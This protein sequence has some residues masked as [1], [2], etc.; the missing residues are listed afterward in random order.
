MKTYKGEE[1][2]V[3]GLPLFRDCFPPKCPTM[4]LAHC[5]KL[6]MRSD[7]EKRG[8][9]VTING[10]SRG[11][12]TQDIESMRKEETELIDRKRESYLST[13]SPLFAYSQ[14]LVLRFPWIYH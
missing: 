7:R 10:K 11:N 5:Q 1:E 9:K 14:R 3:E 12:A 6:A 8:K 13:L 2:Q 4:C